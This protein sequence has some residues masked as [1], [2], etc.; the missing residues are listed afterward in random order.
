M[1]VSKKSF[2]V[3]KNY[4]DFYKSCRFSIND[5]IFMS[6]LWSMQVL[7]I[8]AIP[9]KK[10]GI[11]VTGCRFYGAKNDA[12]WRKNDVKLPKSTLNQKKNSPYQ[13]V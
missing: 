9:G 13:Q 3:S 10:I 6:F 11:L 7:C 12:K 8:A 4:V 2:R 1:L 5:M